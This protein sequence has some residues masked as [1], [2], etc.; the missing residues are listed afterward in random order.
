MRAE[1]EIKYLIVQAHVHSS[2]EG[3]L[4]CPQ[5]VVARKYRTT[6]AKSRITGAKI[7]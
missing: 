2:V 5:K 4:A 7:W 6:L 3:S 1:S